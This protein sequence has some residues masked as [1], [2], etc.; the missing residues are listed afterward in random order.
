ME[1]TGITAQLFKFLNQ[2]DPVER[3]D[4]KAS[5]MRVGDGFS[6][7]ISNGKKMLNLKI[8]MEKSFY[9]SSNGEIVDL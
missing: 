2:I 9:L 6:V 5:A 7:Q 8:G 1:D 3:T 4:L